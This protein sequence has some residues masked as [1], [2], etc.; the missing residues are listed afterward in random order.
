MQRQDGTLA[1]KTHIIKVDSSVIPEVTMKYNK[2]EISGLYVAIFNRASEG[3]GNRYWQN[4]DKDLSDIAD[5]MLASPDAQEYFGHSLDTNKSFIEH[6]Y[7]NTLGKTYADD[8]DGVDYWVA[9]LDA[10]QSRGEVV[11]TL[12]HDAQ[13][14]V[15][16]ELDAYK[17]FQNRLFVSDYASE[18]LEYAP[19]NYKQHLGFD[20]DLYVTADPHT[21]SPAL[22]VIDSIPDTIPNPADP[23]DGDHSSGAGTEMT[24]AE[25]LEQ[26]LGEIQDPSTGLSPLES[27]DSL[28]LDWDQ[29]FE[30]VSAWEDSFYGSNLD[31]PYDWSNL[32]NLYDGSNWGSLYDGSGSGT[33]MSV[34]EIIDLLSEEIQGGPLAEWLQQPIEPIALHWNEIYGEILDGLG[35]MSNEFGYMSGNIYNQ[36]LAASGSGSSAAIIQ[37]YYGSPLNSEDFMDLVGVYADWISDLMAGY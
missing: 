20:G 33:G 32:G 19:E 37:E 30:A 14:P 25:I 31:D 8:P 9:K 23:G 10:G 13:N 17:Q 5:E 15:F 36:I 18:V 12:I 7:K 3:D 28:A 26:L 1:D 24:L 34:S 11:A 35:T 22:G 2:T 16:S 29:I 27:L 4:M 21:V 6:I